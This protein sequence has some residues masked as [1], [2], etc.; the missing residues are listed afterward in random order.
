MEQ[1]RDEVEAMCHILF[2]PFLCSLNLILCSFILISLILCDALAFIMF[3]LF[4]Y[5]QPLSLHSL[6]SIPCPPFHPPSLCHSTTLIP[7]L[8]PPSPPHHFFPYPC[9]PTPC[10][11]VP[12]Y[13]YLP[14]ICSLL[15]ASLFWLCLPYILS[16][17]TLWV[18]FYI[19]CTTLLTILLWA[20]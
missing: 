20:F 10:F 14:N 13:S 6:I 8:H 15:L 5:L 2:S 11:S 1:E 9:L 7:I 18:I 19:L 17:V 16:L 4:C 3:S 12:S